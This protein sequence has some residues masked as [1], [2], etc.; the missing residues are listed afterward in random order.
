[1]EVIPIPQHLG[2]CNVEAQRSQTERSSVSSSSLHLPLS[3]S[4]KKNST[5]KILQLYYVM[6]LFP[7]CCTKAP[8]K[9][10]LCLREMA[11]F[12]CPQPPLFMLTAHAAGWCNQLKG[13]AAWVLREENG[14][15]E[16]VKEQER[17]GMGGS[18]WGLTLIQRFSFHQLII[19]PVVWGQRSPEI[20]VRC[21]VL[22]FPI[23]SFFRGFSHKSS[24][25]SAQWRRK[26]RSCV[27]K[28]PAVRGVSGGGEDSWVV[29][30]LNLPQSL[31]LPLVL[32]QPQ[33]VVVAMASM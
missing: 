12:L 24:T 16:G 6:F 11:L 23:S 7:V 33:G 1:M 19:W 17:N 20:T 15:K 8:Q 14:F 5:N 26:R 9:Q 21:S 3:E 18:L 25:T 2:L 10:I 22:F 13:E 27:W 30:D 31:R 32:G 4:C 28:V 29:D